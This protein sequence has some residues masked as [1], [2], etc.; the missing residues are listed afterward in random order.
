MIKPHKLGLVFATLLG[1]IHFIWSL[2]VLLGWAQ[3]LVDFSMWAHMVHMMV[4]VGPFDLVSS[5]TVIV[6][7]ACIG[8][9]IGNIVALLWNKLSRS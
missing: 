9:A 3:P 7:A 4:I 1:G 5:A 2:L 8:F 6:I